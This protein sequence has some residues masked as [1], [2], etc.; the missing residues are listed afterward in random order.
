VSDINGED[1]LLMTDNFEERLSRVERRLDTEAGLRAAGDL[2]LSRLEQG[3]RISIRLIQA[4]GDTQSEQ[5]RVLAR[6]TEELKQLRQTQNLHSEVL[7]AQGQ[8]L[9]YHSQVLDKHTEILDQHT[10]TLG[11]HTEVLGQHTEILGQHT[12]TLG[13]HTQTLG[14]HTTALAGLDGKVDRILALLEQG[15]GS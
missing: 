14:Q 8:T 11:Q 10:Q 12:Q 4:L 1:V 15:A 9:R 7:A 5:T 13:Q 3:Q 2:D 6:H